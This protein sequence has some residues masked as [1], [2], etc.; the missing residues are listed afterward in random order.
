MTIAPLPIDL[1]GAPATAVITTADGGSTLVPVA[2]PLARKD[3]D[4]D[5]KAQWHGVHP[6]S[7]WGIAHGA[8]TAFGDWHV[9]TLPALSIVLA[10][11]WEIETTDG[12][13]RQFTPGEVLVTL[14]NTGRGHRS[15]TLDGPCTSL[16]VWLTEEVAAS[17]RNAA[18]GL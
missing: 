18:G 13:T 10:G 7:M 5:G 14:D 6:A 9:S 4:A 15:R 11:G 1:D 2:L 17:L 8:A 12:M 3:T 16:G